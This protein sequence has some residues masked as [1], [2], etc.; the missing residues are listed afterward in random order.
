[1]AAP[2]RGFPN[3]DLQQLK[4][5]LLELQLAYIEA[6]RRRPQRKVKKSL[7]TNP[8]PFS[9]TKEAIMEKVES[10]LDAIA[11]SIFIQQED[12][13]LRLPASKVS[14][15]LYNKLKEISDSDRVC[16]QEDI[17]QVD[18]LLKRFIRQ[19]DPN[20]PFVAEPQESSLK[21]VDSLGITED[22]DGDL[23]TEDDEVR[24]PD[25]RDKTLGESEAPIEDREEG[26]IISIR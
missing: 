5:H 13:N 11:S 1:M 15:D 20:H 22:A 9:D 18:S 3:E 26:E 24:D 12:S 4:S 17:D 19:L 7:K 10:D 2:G 16:T 21:G 14:T 25:Y 6:S 23:G 8:A